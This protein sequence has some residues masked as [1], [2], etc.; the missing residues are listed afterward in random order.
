MIPGIWLT[1]LSLGGKKETIRDIV[2]SPRKRRKTVP[3]KTRPKTRLV[4]Y[5]QLE[6]GASGS[7]GS[8]TA[9]VG[10]FIKSLKKNEE[11]FKYFSKIELAEMQRQRVKDIEV[12]NFKITCY[13]KE[14][15]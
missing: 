2:L 15:N 3:D 11:F 8:E 4:R 12:M 14:T 5:L 13:F 10:R 7:Y 1:E 6:G 9:T